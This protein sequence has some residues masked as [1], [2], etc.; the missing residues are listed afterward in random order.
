MRDEPSPERD[1]Q[2]EPRQAPRI[3]GR[4]R[5]VLSDEPGTT[6]DLIEHSLTWASSHYEIGTS[7]CYGNG[8]TTGSGLEPVQTGTR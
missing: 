4:A 1:D 7:S 2:F 6:I 8:P 3:G 5:H